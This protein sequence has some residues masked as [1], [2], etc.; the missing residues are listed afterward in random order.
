M[1]GRLRRRGSS[2]GASP[3]RNSRT[4]CSVTRSSAIPQWLECTSTWRPAGSRQARQSTIPSRREYT[5]RY[6]SGDGGRA[7]SR[8]NAAQQRPNAHE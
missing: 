6:G 5:A 3:S 7:R 1:R 2:G 8:R 4:T